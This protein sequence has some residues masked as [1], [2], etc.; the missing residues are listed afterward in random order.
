MA[1]FSNQATLTYN[2]TTTNSNIAYGEILDVLAATKTA[3]EGTYTPG[4]PVTYVV[5]LRNTGNSPLTG[6]T[7]TD[8]LGGYAFG[9]GT[10]YPLTYEDGS[11]ALFVDGVPQGA[12][13]VTAG[14]P[15]VISGITVPA[16]GDV[17][18]VYQARA[19]AFADPQAGGT[20]VNTVTVTG[21]GLSAPITASETV[22]AV[23]A[24]AL[25][26]SKSITPTQIVDND[27]VTYTFVI[28]NTGNEAV[29]ATDNAVV[30]DTF[31]PI[32]T[33]LNVTFD[34]VAWTEGV[35]YNYEEATGLFTTNPGQITVPAATYTQDPV[36]G[37]YAL[38][39]GIA[40]LV[41]TGT[42]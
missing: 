12:P 23:T 10:V 11:A 20:I 9:A 14:P 3:V 24:P 8:D 36:T 5:T 38:T 32:L 27:R 7:I 22:T 19:N 13:A 29:V 33:A 39:P 37:A 34:G 2:G 18:V 41:V 15:L 42:I 28:Q 1:I 26:I 31:D 25:T 4:E 40:T 17:V 21:D 35:Q 30:S 16:G 6:I